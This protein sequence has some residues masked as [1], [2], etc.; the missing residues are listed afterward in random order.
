MRRSEIA[1]VGGC[2][3]REGTSPIAR[4]LR[5]IVKTLRLSRAR[6]DEGGGFRAALFVCD[7]TAVTAFRRRTCKT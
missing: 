1:G 7:V 6:Y 5:W 4:L 3:L 2:L